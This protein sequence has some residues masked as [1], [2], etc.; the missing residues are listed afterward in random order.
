MSHAFPTNLRLNNLNAALFADHTAMLHAFI[1][2]AITFKILHRTKN[3]GTEESVAFRL[4]GTVIDSLR[5][6]HFSMGPIHDPFG[7]SKRNLH[8][9]KFYRAFRFLKKIK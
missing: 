4:E 2:S 5:F 8:F 1:L 7:G 6:L 9:I 3:L